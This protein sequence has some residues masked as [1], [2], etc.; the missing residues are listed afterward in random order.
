M[1]L[2][3]TLFAYNF[4]L[5]RLN[6]ERSSAIDRFKSNKSHFVRPKDKT[7]F[8]V[9]QPIWLEQFDFPRIY[10][11][12]PDNVTHIPARISIFEVM[13]FEKNTKYSIDLTLNPIHE[14]QIKLPEP[15]LLQPY[16]FEHGFAYEI[17]LEIQGDEQLMFDE[18]LGVGTYEINQFYSSNIEVVFV[19]DSQS[20]KSKVINGKKYFASQGTVKRLHLKYL[21]GN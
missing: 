16:G 6:I 14:T 3:L 7:W 1:I 11:N 4:G 13:K 20:L 18:E 10:N 19:E 17:H 8:S 21:L 9:N 12:A 5:K 2:V 15:I